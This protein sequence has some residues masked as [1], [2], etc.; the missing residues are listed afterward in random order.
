MKLIHGDCLEEMKQIKDKSIDMILCDLPYGTT[1]CK[2]DV[3]ISFE[4][5]WEQ[6][7]RIIK[8]NGA[9]VLLSSQ[10]FTTD[11]IN[12]NRKMFRYE[13]IWKKTLPTGF[14]NA[15]RMPMRVHENICIF[16][17]HLPTYNPQMTTVERNDVGRIRTNG[18]N[19]KQYNEFRKE[20]W[21]YVETGKRYPVDVIEFSNWN[22]TLFGNTTNATK[23]PTQKPIQ[24]LEWLINTYSNTGD[25]ILDNCMGS[26]STG[27]AA[28]QTGRG[29]IGIEKEKR[30]FD[31]AK[32]RLVETGYE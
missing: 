8:D 18:G 27:V 12:S 28:V 4:K 29:F 6:Y 16:Y 26:G 2:W 20:D 21:N 15:K 22:G 23:H 10:P 17:K 1:K 32:D 7:K 31:I 13:I 30:Y 19:A 25:V 5:L 3:V 14:L 9:I 11:L 24:L